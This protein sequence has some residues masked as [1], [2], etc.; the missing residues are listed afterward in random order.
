[1]DSFVYVDGKK[2]KRGYTTGSCACAATKAATQMFFS[3]QKIENIEIMTPKGIA[4]NLKVD[5][6][7]INENDV[8]CSIKKDGGD[9]IDSTSG[10]DI[11]SKVS[12]V[13]I[14]KVDFSK[15]CVTKNKNI[16]IQNGEGIGKIT[17]PGL[18]VDPGRP[19]INKTPI[20]MIE[21][22]VEKILDSVG[23]L[24]NNKAIKITIFA[25]EGKQIAKKTFNP[26][27]GIIGGISIIGTSGIVEPMSDEGWKK[28]ISIE[29]NMKKKCN[30]DKLVIVPGNMGEKF[31]IEKLGIDEKN[32]VKASNFIGHVLMDIK[33]LEF[34]EVLF[35]GHIG[36]FIKISA[37]IFNTHSR[38]CDAR[39]EI[40]ISNLAMLGA[41]IN[42][43]K[44][45][46][47][48]TTVEGMLEIIDKTKYK[49]VYNIIAEKIV[50]RSIA[51]MRLD[52]MQKINIGVLMF[53]MKNE[54]LGKSNDF[55]NIIKKN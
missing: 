40:M 41:D 24:S 6:I 45:I 20:Q 32:I 2:Y 25:P 39:S 26:K 51:H 11:F 16:V 8:S 43:L 13:N 19:A 14:D 15:V 53:S 29:L 33:R 5:N 3:K 44:Q 49:K 34:K 52:D 35:I 21:N 17:K 46:E 9:D 47:N 28:S 7:D 10:M 4:L 22:E 48:C 31:A 37:G 18:S 55:D 1:M 54:M 42:L 30:I 12:F 23:G 27:L 50:E 38:V 36:K